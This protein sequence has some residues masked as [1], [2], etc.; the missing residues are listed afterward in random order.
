M[1]NNNHTGRK[2]AI[3]ALITGIG[4]Y[5]VGILTAPKSGKETRADIADKA[6]DIKNDTRV[7][8]ENLQDDLRELLARAKDKT[9]QLSFYTRRGFDR[10]VLRAKD[11]SDKSKEILKA[12]KTGESEDP[13]LSRAVKQ[14]RQAKANLSKYLKK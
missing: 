3:G 9:V 2:W 8:L 1:A 6:E 14:A 10:A 12:A 4:G 5:L 7:E 11:A 13:Q